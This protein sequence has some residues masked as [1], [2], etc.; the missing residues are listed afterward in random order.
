[1]SCLTL[2][3]LGLQ[4]I[5]LIPSCSARTHRNP[6]RRKAVLTVLRNRIAGGT[7]SASSTATSVTR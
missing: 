4:A 6:S 2:T 3:L 1:V 7:P 5:A